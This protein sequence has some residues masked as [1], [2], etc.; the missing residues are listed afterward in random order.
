MLCS[1]TRT[2]L[3]CAASCNNV[4]VCKFLVESGAAVF[5]ATYSDMQT[6]ADKCEEME[7]G[8]TQCSQFLY[9]VYAHLNTWRSRSLFL[10]V[11]SPFFLLF[12][13]TPGKITGHACMD[14]KWSTLSAGLNGIQVQRH[15]VVQS[16]KPHLLV[17]W[18]EYGRITFVVGM[19]IHLGAS[20]AA[21]TDRWIIA[22]ARKHIIIMRHCR[23]RAGL[24]WCYNSRDKSSCFSWIHLRLKWNGKVNAAED[25]LQWKIMHKIH[26]KKCPLETHL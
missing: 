11:C 24:R 2:P 1:C 18:D 20:R 4:Q 25:F 26:N 15:I 21:T 5:A 7:E 19:L 16:P 23:N 13:I 10:L 22:V 17:V 12:L 3:H 14:H 8:Y 6:A 9:G